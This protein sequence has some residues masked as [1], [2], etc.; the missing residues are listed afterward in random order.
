MAIGNRVRRT[1]VQYL[2][3]PS[4][5]SHQSM[6]SSKSHVPSGLEHDPQ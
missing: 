6:G 5:P 1:C 2:G 3:K 4:F